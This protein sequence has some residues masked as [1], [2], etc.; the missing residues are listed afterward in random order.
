MTQDPNAAAA[1]SS[2]PRTAS[3]NRILVVEDEAHLATG[4]KL[5]LELEGYRC[6]VATTAREAAERLVDA[7]G[8]DAIVLDVMLPDMD[9]FTLLQRL[10]EAGNFIPVI[11]LTARGAAEDRVRGLEVGADDYLVKPF[12]LE[13]LLARIRS[14]LRRRRWERGSEAAQRRIYT[15]DGIRVDFESHE[16]VVRGR[17]VKLTALE[18]DLLRYFTAN[19]GRVIGREELLEKVWRLRNYE[20]TRTVDNFVGRLRRHFERDPK[21]PRYFVSVRGAGYKFVPPRSE[22]GEDA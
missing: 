9:G 21:H 7:A 11:M 19:P 20:T 15:F 13:E 12:D 4:L 6:E 18:L 3:G 1:A 8:F 16:V 10:R 14:M 17:P 5:N 2:E 22:G